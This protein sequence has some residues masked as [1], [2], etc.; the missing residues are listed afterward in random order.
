LQPAAPPGYIHP[1]MDRLPERRSGVVLIVDDDPDISG[2]LAR[3]VASPRLTTQVAGTAADAMRVLSERPVALVLLDLL[4]PDADGRSVLARLREEPATS[5]IPVIVLSA[6]ASA[7]S[8]AECYALGAEAFIVKPF[9]PGAVTAAVT[10]T[11]ERTGR[12]GYDARLDPDTSLPNRAAFREAFERA[13]ASPSAPPIS[14]ALLELDQYRSLAAS[15]GWGSAARA[16]AYAL[17]LLTEALHGAAAVARWTGG[18]CAALLVGA[19]ED[20]ATAIVADALKAVRAAEPADGPAPAFTFTAGVAERPAGGSL[21]ETLAEAESQL[22]AARAAGFDTARSAAR[23]GATARQVVLLAED[24]ELVASVV[25]HRL[26]REGMTVRRFTDGA[27]AAEAAP[28]LRPS[29][30]ILD[31][32]LPGLD[33]FELL[34]RLR[35][36]AS[37]ARMPIMLLTSVGSER[38]VVRGLGLGA[39]DYVVKPFSPLEVVARVHRLLLRR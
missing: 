21:A 22:V 7:Q 30:A 18:T 11:L 34:G 13:A 16:L 12:R 5:G 6:H 31:A 1:R 4:L 9:D 32:K 19:R 24:D 14:V 26:E 27:A 33:G 37:L 29:L 10:A 38:D 35:A 3:V 2:L 25:T 39:D 8:Q 23:P 15:H 28:K 17:R 20:D 36:D